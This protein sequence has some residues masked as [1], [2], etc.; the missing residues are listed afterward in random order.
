METGVDKHEGETEAFLEE[1]KNTKSS[2][3]TPSDPPPT[4]KLV[5]D[6][7]QKMSEDIMAQALQLC[8]EMDVHYKDFPFIDI[9]SEYVI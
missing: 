9:E 2:E 8:W 4:R 7:A 5:L 6:L 1:V 3:E